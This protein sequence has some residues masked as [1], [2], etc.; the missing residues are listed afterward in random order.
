MIE[1]EHEDDLDEQID[2]RGEGDIAI[3]AWP[4]SAASPSVFDLA[5]N[6]PR[7]IDEMMMH[8]S[9]G[10]L[11]RAQVF[12]QPLHESARGLAMVA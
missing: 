1:R 4:G 7:G 6:E 3:P 2:E 12:L 9:D 11:R 8:F 10:L 5:Q